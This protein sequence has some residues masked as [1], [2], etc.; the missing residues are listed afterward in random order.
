MSTST[1]IEWRMANEAFEFAWLRFD[2]DAAKRILAVV[3]HEI[4]D[5]IVSDVSRWLGPPPT[6]RMPGRLTMAGVIVDW[7]TVDTDEVDLTVPVI[8]GQLSD[9]AMPID[10]WRR[11]AKATIHG[12][13][14]LPLVVLTRSET[15]EVMS[16]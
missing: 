10:G 4:T 8:L 7:G 11:I 5:L 16:S 15:R 12:I 6:L 13:S 14:V 2:V 3:P 1:D 9:S